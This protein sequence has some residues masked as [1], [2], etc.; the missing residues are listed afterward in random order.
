MGFRILFGHWTKEHI[1]NTYKY[2]IYKDLNW[3]KEA[4]KS[5]NVQQHTFVTAKYTVMKI[6]RTKNL[7]QSNLNGSNTFGTMKI[8]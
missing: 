4:N 7:Y 3:K 6:K 8:S 1:M 5:Q 2:F